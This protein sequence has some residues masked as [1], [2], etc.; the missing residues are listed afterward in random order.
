MLPPTVDAALLPEPFD[1]SF[2]YVFALIL[3]PALD[4]W[5]YDRLCCCFRF[6]DRTSACVVSYALMG[7][8]SAYVAA[9]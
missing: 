2:S 6:A 4:W 8:T 3:L 7:C 5:V 1:F 9:F